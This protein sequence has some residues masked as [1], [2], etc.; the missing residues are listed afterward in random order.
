MRAD[1]R[2]GIEDPGMLISADDDAYYDDE[3]CSQEPISFGLTDS[4]LSMSVGFT[5]NVSMAPERHSSE[6]LRVRVS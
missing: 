5:T 4:E 3:E 6:A 1:L 2:A